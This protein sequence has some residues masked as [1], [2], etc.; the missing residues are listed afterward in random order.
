MKSGF[1]ISELDNLLGGGLDKCT[2]NLIVGRNGIGKTILASQWAAQ[3][4]KNG[5]KVVYLST[6]LVPKSCE[7]Y[8]SRFHFMED[9]YEKIH[10]KFQEIESKSF[11]PLTKEKI[12]QTIREEFG[13]GFDEV[14]RFVFDSA[15]SLEKAL[16]DPVLYRRAL[17]YLADMCYEN[18]V[19]AI[20][21][22]EAPYYG[23]WSE[24]RHIAECIILLD[25]L[26]VP[27]GY[28]RALRILKKY[29]TDHPLDYIP[30]EITENG[31]ELKEGR[32]VRVNYEFKFELDK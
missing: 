6:T 28:A 17:R 32:Y 4:A 31:I 10:W 25:L 27:T 7:T 19:T 11:I 9:I 29:R 12:D 15:S 5:E 13:I 3:G 20:F 1:G 26:R 16:G 2:V 30:F 8:L 14:D 21:I 24:A 18:D 23:E 22:E